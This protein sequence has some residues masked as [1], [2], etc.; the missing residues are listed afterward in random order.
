MVEGIFGTY[1][2]KHHAN[3]GKVRKVL[4]V[5][6]EYRETARRCQLLVSIDWTG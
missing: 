2:F 5:L 1:E 6:R 4:S 3:K